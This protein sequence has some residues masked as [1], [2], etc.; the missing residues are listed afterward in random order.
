VPELPEV[1]TVVRLIRPR[2]VGR[3]I[4]DATFTIPRQLQPQ[5]A[6]EILR[7]VK[8]HSVKDV[9]RRGKYILI[10]LDNGTLLVHLRMTGKL[11]VRSATLDG[12]QHER[13]LFVLDDGREKLVLH[14]PRT[15]GTIRFY[16]AGT[17]IPALE[18]LGKEPLEEQEDIGVMLEK[19]QRRSMAIKPLLLNQSLFA[20][21]GNIYA[22]E[23]LWVAKIDPRRPANELTRAELKRLTAAVRK[24]LLR[25]IEK[26]GSTL[27]NFADPE[28][29]AG[30]YQKE[31]SVYGREG[32]PCLHCGKPVERMVQAQRATYFCKGC[33]K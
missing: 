20:G 7:A 13:A 33:Q 5:T 14:D 3:T 8:G 19:L 28:G 9:R 32:E 30:S 15:L 10:E 21:V 22:S 25:A 26:G 23:A 17:A 29:R 31:F 27:R 12:G 11:Y 18:G 24:V 6:R 1:E 2:L 16:P 4:R